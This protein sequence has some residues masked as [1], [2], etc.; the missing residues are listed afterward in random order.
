MKHTIHLIITRENA[1][2]LRFFPSFIKHK[3]YQEPEKSAYPEDVGKIEFSEC[4]FRFSPY[5]GTVIVNSDEF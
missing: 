4:I 3:D 2:Y 1:Y 5:K